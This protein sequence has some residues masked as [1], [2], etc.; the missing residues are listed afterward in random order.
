M[1]V[2]K[3]EETLTDGRKL[4]GMPTEQRLQ[5]RRRVA[6]KIIFRPVQTLNDPILE[7]E[8]KFINPHCLKFEIIK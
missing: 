5:E 8:V 6:W 1:N 3:N 2:A 4:R 7:E